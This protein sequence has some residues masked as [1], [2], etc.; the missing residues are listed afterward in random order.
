MRDAIRD[1]Y[2]SI[3]LGTAFLLQLCVPV[4]IVGWGYWLWMSAKFGNVWMF[5]LG[6]FPQLGPFVAPIGAYCL[7]F[8]IPRWM[9]KVF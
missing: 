4:L 2:S 7:L 9:Y 1:V 3:L 6:L 5:V 8:D